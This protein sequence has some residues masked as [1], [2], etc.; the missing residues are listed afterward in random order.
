MD[1]L[2]IDLRYA[3]RS[4]RKSRGFTLAAIL[5][6]ALG[7]G[8]NTAIFSYVDA[9][10]LRPLPVRD[11]G[12]IVRIFTSEYDSTGGHPR[13]PSSYPDYLD[14][15]RQAATFADVLTYDRRAAL[16]YQADA[17]TMIPA[18]V[19]SA[20]Y[21]TV[22]GVDAMV[23]RVFTE[24][25][26]AGFKDHPSVVISYDLWRNRFGADPSLPGRSVRLTRSIVT[27]LGVLPRGFHG[28]DLQSPTA[29][30][31]PIGVWS[32][33][34]GAA[35]EFTLRGDRRREI[36]ARLRPD[37]SLAQAQAQLDL[38]GA[39][40]AG[41]YPATNKDSRFTAV[42]ESETRGEA[43]R[44]QGVILLAIALAVAL[45]AAANLANLQLVRAETRR[46]ETATRLAIGGGAW[47]L[48]RSW[49]VEGV[50]LSLV[51]C[52]IAIA[53]GGSIIRLLPTLFASSLIGDS[54]YDFRL[55]WRVLLFT[56]AVASAATTVF[57]LA[58]M[59]Q[60]TRLDVMT[61]LRQGAA[62]GSDRHQLGVRDVLI[63]AQVAL[64]IALLTGAGL[65]ART[66]QNLQAVDPGFNPRQDVLML[67]VVPQLAYQ[68]ESELHGYYQSVEDRFRALPGVQQ[69][70]LVQRVPFSP[71]LGGAEKEIV[72]PGLASPPGAAGFRLT[73][74]VVGDGYFSLMG[75]RVLRGRVFDRQDRLDSVKVVIVNETMARRFW[76]GR[77]AVGKQIT[78]ATIDYEI[79]GVVDDTKWETLT[80][81]PRSLLY[82]PITQQV[83]DGLTILLRT[84]NDPSLLV[85]AA[86]T[87]LQ[88]V[89]SNVPLLSV[90]TLKQHLEFTINDERTRARLTSVFAALGLALAATGLYGILAFLVTRRTREIGIRIAVGAE[91]RHV[92]LLV[93]DYGL[94]RVVVG[95]AVG[96]ILSLALSRFIAGLLFGVAPADPL[97]LAGVLLLHVAVAAIAGYAP[98]RRAARVDPIVA[99]RAE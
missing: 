27:I 37:F 75:V 22:L 20:N 9:T 63:V 54:S 6:V 95:L 60:T 46:Y 3:L 91:S 8:A 7:M 43:H 65:L 84:R 40:L 82:F 85:Q 1:A 30:W 10:W 19:V 66:F 50:V 71:F 70:A 55:D 31:I 92:V 67:Y 48:L 24:S 35:A 81:T 89:N 79:V 23:G 39:R 47:Q 41:E 44:I 51:G 33:T 11:P 68:R 59:L 26:S 38:I 69:V 25:E 18:E 29:V 64:S 58:P 62:G 99:L 4:L 15:H 93:L 57:G 17:T 16:L 14:L 32:Q 42:P 83:S 12:R 76:P 49:L 80:E 96:L 74:D 52:A 94:R 5:I 97:I 98:A 90:A 86:R 45:I 28:L 61:T 13:G 53:L 73:Y 88:R 77:D 34:P 72:V 78:I 21:F 36:L 2:W 87:E 56:F